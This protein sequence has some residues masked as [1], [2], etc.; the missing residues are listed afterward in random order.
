M[1]KQLLI[2]LSLIAL[3]SSCST[4]E[5][6]DRPSFK[7]LSFETFVGKGTPTRAV[8]KTDFAEGDD[9]GGIAYRHGTDP[10]TDGVAKELFMDN[11]EVTRPAAAQ[12]SHL[13]QT[14]PNALFGIISDRTGIDQNDIR[15]LDLV[16]IDIPLLLHDRYDDLGI[17]DIHLTTVG[18]YKKF[19]ARPL[20]RTQGIYLFFVIHIHSPEP[21]GKIRTE[22]RESTIAVPVS[23]V[24]LKITV[25]ELHPLPGRA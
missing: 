19:T 25:P 3:L 7:A 11:V 6:V 5:E 23:P 16:G 14:P 17:A 10:W 4:E 22:K 20:Q 2:T 24:F 15:L 8:A 12:M 21:P 18:F 13:P 9:F 1:K